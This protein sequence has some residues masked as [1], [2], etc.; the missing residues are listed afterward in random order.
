MPTALFA[1]LQDDA[2]MVVF[3]FEVSS[4][5]AAFPSF[6]LFLEDMTRSS[7]EDVSD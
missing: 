5:A 3:R 4:L 2:D 7:G 1:R 6:F